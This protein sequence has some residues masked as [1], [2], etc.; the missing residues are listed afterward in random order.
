[1]KEDSVTMAKKS[2]LMDEQIATP[3]RQGIEQAKQKLLTY[4]EECEKLRETIVS[5]EEV[6]NGTS[7]SSALRLRDQ[8]GSA[9]IY[10]ETQRIE[11]I[12]SAFSR[13]DVEP[14]GRNEI[15]QI[16][17]KDFAKMYRN[18]KNGRNQYSNDF[19][20]VARDLEKQQKI[21]RT[22]DGG[23]KTQALFVKA[24]VSSNKH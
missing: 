3:I 12:Q 21:T 6:L 23:G 8:N 5:L 1:M 2:A 10:S 17:D 14:F 13:V 7:P 18:T 4:E 24:S 9:E 20:R 16:I 22:R 19:W 15:R 11:A